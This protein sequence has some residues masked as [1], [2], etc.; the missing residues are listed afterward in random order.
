[1]SETSEIEANQALAKSNQ[2][3][4]ESIRGLTEQLAKSLAPPNPEAIAELIS[5]TMRPLVGS[6]LAQ[7]EA[8]HPTESS[9]SVEVL[10]EPSDVEGV[11][12]TCPSR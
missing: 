5:Q 3:L 1:M 10:V 6:M 9:S 8:K 7:L 12:T 2:A 4:A 11:R